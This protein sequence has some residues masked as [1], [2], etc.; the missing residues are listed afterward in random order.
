MSDLSVINFF[1]IYQ[2]RKRLTFNLL[3]YKMKTGVI[4][5]RGCSCGSRYI[6]ERNSNP[7]VRWNEHRNPTKGSEPSKQLRNNINHRFTQTIISNTR[8]KATTGKSLEVSY[9]AL[10]KPDLNRLVLFRYCVTQKNQ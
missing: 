9:I 7:E 3:I 10:W 8:K 1:Y 4:Y 6:D 2:T 5:K